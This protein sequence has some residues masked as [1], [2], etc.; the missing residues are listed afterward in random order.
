MTSILT[1]S[2][3]S[4]RWDERDLTVTQKS[5]TGSEDTTSHLRLTCSPA[6]HFTGRGIF[7][8]FHTLWS[9][10]SI[11]QLSS[12]GATTSTSRIWFGGDTG[13]K[14]VPRGATT[15][16]GLPT[17]PAYKEIGEKLGPFDLSMIPIGAYSP[18][19][20]MSPIHLS[21]E[22]AVEVHKE[23]KSKKSIGMHW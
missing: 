2:K 16:E 17:C 21:P 3:I 11:A 6:Q 10:W 22:D 5:E 13:Y 8:R 19:F 23:T 18:R 1:F 9:S 12:S 20:F 4:E 7:D 14:S 15:E